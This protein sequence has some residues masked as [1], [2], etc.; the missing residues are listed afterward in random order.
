[1][2]ETNNLYDGS[3]AKEHLMTQDKLVTQTGP[4]EIYYCKELQLISFANQFHSR[5]VHE[6]SLEWDWQRHEDAF[7]DIV[8]NDQVNLKEVTFRANAVQVKTED[9]TYTFHIN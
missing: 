2:S 6:T 7:G 5:I 1:M 3:T 8:H 4:H 9:E